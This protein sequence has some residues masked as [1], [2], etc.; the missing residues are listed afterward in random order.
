MSSNP[1]NLAPARKARHDEAATVPVAVND[2]LTQDSFGFPSFERD[3]IRWL[4]VIH[5]VDQSEFSTALV[6]QQTG[7]PHGSS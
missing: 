5:H 6:R 4:V 1:C 7:A 3:Q 2:L